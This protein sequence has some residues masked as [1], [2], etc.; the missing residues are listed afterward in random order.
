MWSVEKGPKVR[1]NGMGWEGK[2]ETK[3]MEAREWSRENWGEGIAGF[4]YFY[5]GA[6]K[7]RGPAMP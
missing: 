4:L 6:Q 3:G 2:R 5:G 7:Q 1:A